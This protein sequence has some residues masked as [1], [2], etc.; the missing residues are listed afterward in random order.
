MSKRLPLIRLAVQVGML[1]LFL[2][3]LAATLASGRV[4]WYLAL[5]AR[6]VVAFVSYWRPREYGAADSTCAPAMPVMAGAQAD[7]RWQWKHTAALLAVVAAP[8][9]QLQTESPGTKAT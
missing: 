7:E 1:G 6:L 3:P 4:W 8:V 9:V 5:S 2:L